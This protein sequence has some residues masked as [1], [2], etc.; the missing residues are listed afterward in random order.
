MKEKRSETCTIRLDK[1]T[2]KLAKELAYYDDR[3][4]SSWVESLIKKE[5]KK[6]PKTGEAE[7]KNNV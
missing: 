5:L 7:D 3:T 2:K 6:H 4:L 1:E